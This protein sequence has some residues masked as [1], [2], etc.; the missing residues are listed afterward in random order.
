M[1]SKI[2]DFTLPEGTI[3]SVPIRHYVTHGI[4]FLFYG[5]VKYI[6]SPIGDK[7]RLLMCWPVIKKLNR[8]RLYEG[9]TLWYPYSISFGKNVSLNEYVY[10]NAFGGVSIGDNVRIGHRTSIISSDHIFADR[11]TPIHK[12]GLSHAPV[13]IDDD[14]W[15][16]CNVSILS[17]VHIGR[18]AVIAAGSVVN[19][20]VA[21]FA[22]I[23]GVP[24]RQI[25]SR[26]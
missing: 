14:V 2:I 22:I 5:I 1:I 8:V 26:E 15:I 16:G 3:F 17:G 11:D 20:N 6:P 7:L 23:G 4:F 9:V 19:K 12:Q 10:I 25:G 21:A 24:G 18:G 13:T